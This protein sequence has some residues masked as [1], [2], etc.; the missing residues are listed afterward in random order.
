MKRFDQRPAKTVVE[1]V[2]GRERQLGLEAASFVEDVEKLLFAA[3]R[4][5]RRLNDQPPSIVHYEIAEG[6]KMTR[7]GLIHLVPISRFFFAQR[8]WVEIPGHFFFQP[9]FRIIES[10]EIFPRV[11]DNDSSGRAAIDDKSFRN[12]A[13]ARRLLDPFQIFIHRQRFSHSGRFVPPMNG[14]HVSHLRERKELVLAVDLKAFPSARIRLAR[15]L[16]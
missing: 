14:L 1:I 6:R 3:G 12:R 7:P 11:S 15:D 13:F 8:D 4:P 2:P 10:E 9:S 5:F 16:N